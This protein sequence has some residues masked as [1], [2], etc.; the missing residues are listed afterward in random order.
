MN[1]LSRVAAV[2]FAIRHYNLSLVIRGY[3]AE[4]TDFRFKNKFLFNVRLFSVIIRFHLIENG[5][6]TQ[7]SQISK[8]VVA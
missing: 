6:F 4:Q 2:G 1:L 3:S 8:N 5:T 7:S